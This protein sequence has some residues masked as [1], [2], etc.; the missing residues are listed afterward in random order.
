MSKGTYK[1]EDH[2]RATQNRASLGREQVF[3]S[4]KLDPMLDPQYKRFRECLQV[5][6][7]EQARPVKIDL[8]LTGSMSTIP[9]F[10]V[11]N[12]DRGLPGM[13]KGLYPFL[14]HPQLC[15]CGIGD[16]RN[17]RVEPAPFQFGHFEGEGHK[18][19]KWLTKFWFGGVDGGGN[20]G[21]SYELGLFGAARMVSVDA[22]AHGQKGF[23]FII[24]DD[25][26]F[27]D[28]RAMDVKRV[29]GVDIDEDMLVEQLIAELQSDWH[30][31][32]I[33]P[34]QNRFRNVESNWRR[35]FGDNALAADTHQ[36]V[37]VL[38]CGLVGL[39]EGT[40]TD[41][42][43]FDRLMAEMFNRSSSERGRVLARLEAYAATLNKAGD[44]RGSDSD[45]RPQSRESGNERV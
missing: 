30:T 27:P 28:V 39:A 44:K 11:K 42:G 16:A 37:T 2:A 21:E 25:N 40:L 24:A 13:V 1:F 15:F 33:A 20:G 38:I 31:F 32:I 45:A 26:L 23:H 12:A 18:M 14:T 19:D 7:Y 5:P 41:L 22:F 9:E 8:D 6:P 17:Y 4:S 29:C 43:E 36:D 34:D 3:K 10:L 35:Y